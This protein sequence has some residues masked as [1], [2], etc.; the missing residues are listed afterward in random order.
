MKMHAK[1]AASN[2]EVFPD[3]GAVDPFCLWLGEHF[4]ELYHFFV[5]NASGTYQRRVIT[6]IAFA[7]TGLGLVRRRRRISARLIMI[8]SI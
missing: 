2:S 6:S 8:P 4:S 1:N 5:V 3:L 7:N